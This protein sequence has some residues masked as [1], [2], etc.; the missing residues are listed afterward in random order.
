MTTIPNSE[1]AWFETWFDSPYY[2]LLYQKRDEAE[3]QLFIDHL[4]EVWQPPAGA[5]LLDLACG[6]GRY[7]RYL[8]NKGYDVTGLDLSVSSIE[9]ARQFEHDTLSFYTHDMRHL[10]RANYFNGVF[11]FFTSFGYF[12]HPGDDLR[13]LQSVAAGLQ[14]DGVFVLDFFNSAYVVS[15]LSGPEVKTVAGITFHTHKRLE[16]NHIIKDISFADAGQRFFFR[17]QVALLQQTDF[18][19]LFQQAGLRIIHLF[20][21]Y[22]LEAFDAKKSPRLILMAQKI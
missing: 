6:R 20:G 15:Q 11:S 21:N 5:R 19:R 3:A 9:Y 16:G 4:L 22:Q 1:P 12:D 10:F 17:E 18:D 13:T 7:S 8:A 14:K 2:H